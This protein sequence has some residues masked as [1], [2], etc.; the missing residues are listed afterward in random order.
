MK[1]EWL[2]FFIADVAGTAASHLLID[3]VEVMKKELEVKMGD[4]FLPNIVEKVF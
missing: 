4:C 2:G 1:C 3:M